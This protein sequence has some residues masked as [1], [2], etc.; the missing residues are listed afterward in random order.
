MPRRDPVSNR[1]SNAFKMRRNRLQ[2]ALV[3]YDNGKPTGTRELI[4]WKDVPDLVKAEAFGRLLNVR[5]LD[6]MTAA[7]EAAGMDRTDPLHWYQ[8]MAFFAW[9]H[10]GDSR[11]K[12]RPPEWDALRYCKL[13][14]DF[15]DK[16]RSNP[17]LSDEDVFKLLAKT[18]SYKTAKGPLSTSRLRKALKEANDPD[19]NELLSVFQLGGLDELQNDASKND[20]AQS[21]P[22]RD[23]DE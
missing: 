16:K 21:L 5:L 7:F 12:G 20:P 23:H 11:K 4:E 15:D 22:E 14:K 2:V 6:Q 17:A 19:C 13:I 1:L 3:S 8:L 10:F 9:A 18:A